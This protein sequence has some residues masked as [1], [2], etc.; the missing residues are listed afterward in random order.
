MHSNRQQNLSDRTCAWRRAKRHEPVPSNQEGASPCRRPARCPPIP[1]FHPIE[2]IT[3]SIANGGCGHE[4]RFSPPGLNGR[5]RFGQATF[6]GTHGNEQDAPMDE[7][8]LAVIG[9][10]TWS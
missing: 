1:I 7:T 8:A 3:A 2:P 4:E 5:C 10:K 9:G 6:T